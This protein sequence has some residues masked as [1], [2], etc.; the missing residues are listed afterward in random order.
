MP[1]KPLDK[2]L[3]TLRDDGPPE[4]PAALPT[5]SSNALHSLVDPKG[6]LALIEMMR[7]CGRYDWADET[8]RGI[9][10]SVEKAQIVTAGQHKAVLKIR[11]SIRNW[12]DALD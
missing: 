5:E 8:L 3:R 1:G 9:Y 11:E 12:E 7:E 4:A 10:D 2:V 6:F